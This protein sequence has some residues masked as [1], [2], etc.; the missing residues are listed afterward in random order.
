MSPLYLIVN[1]TYVSYY[2]LNFSSECLKR[3]EGDET[4]V[5]VKAFVCLFIWFRLRHILVSCILDYSET[6]YVTQADLKFNV[7]PASAFQMLVAGSSLC[8]FIFFCST[9]V[10]FSDHSILS[11]CIYHSLIGTVSTLSALSSMSPKHSKYFNT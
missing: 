9:S 8:C 4:T 11:L 7:P 10:I 5:I 6:H 3:S 2:A 1:A